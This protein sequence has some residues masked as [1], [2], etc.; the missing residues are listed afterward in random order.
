MKR[1]I[2]SLIGFEIGATDGNIG[3]VSEFYF[4]DETWGLRYMIVETGS[5]LLGRKVLIP[6]E[7]FLK[8]DWE[9][10]LFHVNITKEQVKNS[11]DTDTEKTVT[12]RQEILLN[13]HYLLD[14]YW[15]GGFYGGGMV[16]TPSS[17]PP[18]PDS[19]TTSDDVDNEYH[20]R[21]TKSVTGYNIH[22]V[23][24]TIGE[25]IDF[26]FDDSRWRVDFLVVDTGNWL[27]AKH[28]LISPTWITR[29]NWANSEV[30]VKVLKELIKSSPEY[31]R[32]KELDDVYITMLHSHYT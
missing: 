30:H 17:A 25:I 29:I 15:Q 22:A 28:V 31:D 21:S 16:I 3:K 1:N 26:V 7:S 6:I 9:K 11:P 32:A 13:E 12:R 18:K 10:E 5:W 19:N 8:P 2:R 14:N 27:P 20:L 4:D 24:G 23:D